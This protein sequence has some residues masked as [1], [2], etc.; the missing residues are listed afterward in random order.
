MFDTGLL[1]ELQDVVEGKESA[2]EERAG[3]LTDWT[4]RLNE[5]ATRRPGRAL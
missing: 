1:E 5:R 4:D 3:G 2:A